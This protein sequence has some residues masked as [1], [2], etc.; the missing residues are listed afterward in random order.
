M[1]NKINS[2]FNFIEIQEDARFVFI[3]SDTLEI[4]EIT[5]ELY[6]ILADF[7]ND[8]V[9]SDS[10]TQKLMEYPFIDG[11]NELGLARLNKLKID[12]IHL[13]DDEINSYA[14]DIYSDYYMT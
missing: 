9:L 13:F 14:S 4:Y 1:G 6:R 2:R 10:E 11:G 8:K 5:G 7:L 12:D 3:D